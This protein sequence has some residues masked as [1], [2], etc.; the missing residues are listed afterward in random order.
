V[1][2]DRS[3]LRRLIAWLILATVLFAGVAGAAYV[4]PANTML[5]GGQS[6]DLR[7]GCSDAD[8]PTLCADYRYDDRAVVK[9]SRTPA[10]GD[11][12]TVQCLHQVLPLPPLAWTPTWRVPAPVVPCEPIYLL[13]ARLRN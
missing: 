5:S 8:Q 3:T 2:H 13:T 6:V 9:D 7:V 10:D 1:K 12:P 4:C 11:L